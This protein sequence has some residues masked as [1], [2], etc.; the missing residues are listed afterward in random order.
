MRGYLKTN[1]DFFRSVNS[2]IH[3]KAE[4]VTILHGQIEENLFDIKTVPSEFLVR[5][6]DE[7]GQRFGEAIELPRLQQLSFQAADGIRYFED[8]L[9]AVY[10]GGK[11][12]CADLGFSLANPHDD[13][14]VNY[15]LD[16]K[17]IAIKFYDLD[18]ESYEKPAM[19]EGSFVASPFG[20]GLNLS[21]KYYDYYFCH[22]QI[23]VV[24]DFFSLPVPTVEELKEIDEDPSVTK[25]FGLSYESK[26]L[27]PV[28]LKRYFYPQDPK[29]EY[30]LFDEV[31]EGV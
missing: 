29:L 30:I 5:F 20:L 9:M 2:S 12:H 6:I 11:T 10:S 1:I 28:K 3:P 21:K 13:Y 25:V 26:T 24:A 7:I 8:K 27:K 18:I 17:E 23:Q 31:G 19:P 22:N 15:F 4:E 16:S 14:C